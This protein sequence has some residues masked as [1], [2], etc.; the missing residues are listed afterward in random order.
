MKK[1]NCLVLVV[2]EKCSFFHRVTVQSYRERIRK[3]LKVEASTLKI[4]CRILF[5]TKHLKRVDSSR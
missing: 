4:P 3:L 1:V 5:D 2:T